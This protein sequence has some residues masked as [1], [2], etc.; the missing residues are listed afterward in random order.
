M[1]VSRTLGVSIRVG[2]ALAAI[3]LLA[4]C[5]VGGQVLAGAASGAL[6]AVGLKP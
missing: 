6:E 1:S 4:S 5:A 3:A 2:A